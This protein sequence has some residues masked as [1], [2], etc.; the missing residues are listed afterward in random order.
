M[1]RFLLAGIALL[2]LTVQPALAADRP[3][4][5]A[6]PLAPVDPIFNW[7]GFYVGGTAG[8]AGTDF[9]WA[10]NP[11]LPPPAGNQAF[12]LG[13]SG[14]IFGATAGVQGQWGQWVLGVEFNYLWP[15]RNW[16][17]HAGY[18]VGA[19]F[20]DARL[21]NLLTVGPRFGW[22]N[23]NW[24]L[25][26][27]GGYANGRI[28]TRGDPFAAPG[29]F[30]NQTRYSHD[31][32][33]AGIGFDWAITANLILGVEYQHISLSTINHCVNPCVAGNTNN[34]DMSADIDLVRARLTWLFHIP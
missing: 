22:A 19:S 3:V 11:A 33:F 17:R 23:N 13:N 26:V 16:A 25:F 29:A 14:G 15:N 9:D 34:H 27:T 21:G 18:G 7:S 12:T 28:E 32:W 1:K 8:W 31:G 30:F 24:L 4:Y 6:P 10:F 5:K 20:A 2:A